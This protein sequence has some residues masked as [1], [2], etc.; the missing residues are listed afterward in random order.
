[1]KV[2]GELQVFGKMGVSKVVGLAT[3]L[4]DLLSKSRAVPGEHTENSEIFLK[5]LSDLCG[6]EILEP[7]LL[8]TLGKLDPVLWLNH[9]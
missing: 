4:P 9:A 3:H 5:G 1:M 2:I 6:E 8:D 7:I